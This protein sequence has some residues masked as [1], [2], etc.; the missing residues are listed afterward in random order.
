MAEIPYKS[1][2]WSLM[3]VMVCTQQDIAHS[4]GV[5]SQYLANPKV[6]HRSAIKRIMHHLK[7]TSI[8]HGLIYKKKSHLNPLPKTNI[9]C[10]GYSNI[11]D[12]ANDIDTIKSSFGYILILSLGI[13]SWTGKRQ[14]IIYL[15][16]TK[17]MYIGGK[18]TI[19]IGQQ[20][21]K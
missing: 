2:V 4:M 9:I 3:Y 1:I 19:W 11:I 5:V 21:E 17:A 20:I 12:W 13:K 8:T 6:I 18:R 16:S 10:H 7:R 15:F 14:T